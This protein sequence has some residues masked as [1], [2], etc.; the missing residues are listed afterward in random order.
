MTDL[1]TFEE[2][3]PNDVDAVGGKGL[4][5]ARLAAGG[6]PVPPGFC[7]TTAAYRRLGGHDPAGDPALREA[8]A[9][10]YRRLGG[11]P[12]AVRSSATVE[13]R[14][15]ASFAGQQ[16]TILGVEG[17]DAVCAAVG[18]CWVSLHTERATAYRRRQGMGDDEVAMAVVVQR[19]VAAEVAGVLFTC[20]PLDPDGRRM[21]VE[22]SWGLGESV[23]AGKVTPDRYQIDRDSGAVRERYIGDK[24]VE[25]TAGGEREVE[26]G[27]RGRPCL[28]DKQ[29]AELSALGR[30]VEALYGEPRDVEWAW[31]EGRIWLLQARPITA[32]PEAERQRARREE[33]AAATALAEP[34]GTVW[35][36]IN[37]SESLPAPT[38]MTW[39]LVR[40]LLSGR[41]GQGLMYED[42]GI[43]L[44]KAVR[45]LG[46]FDLIAG[47]TYCN[48]SR[49]ARMAPGFVPAVYRFAALKAAPEQA[50]DPRPVRDPTRLGPLDWLSLPLRLPGIV[51]RSLTQAGRLAHYTRTFADHFRN[52][53]APRFRDEAL[54]AAHDDLT[55]L[56]DEALLARL[57]YWVRRTLDEFARD[58]LKPTALAARARVNVQRWLTRKLGPDRARAAVNELAAG[59]R[60]ESDMAGA[61]R[62]VLAGRIDRAAFLERFG[63][64]GPNEMELASPRWAE[65]PGALGVVS[66]AG[67]APAA[68]DAPAPEDPWERVAAEARLSGLE[69]TALEPQVRVMRT[70][71]ALR[72]EARHHLTY[73]YAQLR[74]VLLQIDRRHRLHGGVFYLTPEELPRLA[75]GQDLS[76]LVA[77]RKRRRV[78]CLTL[79]APAVLFSDDLEAIGRPTNV[80]A[81]EAGSLRGVPLAAGLAEGTV[82]VL[83]EPRTGPVPPGPYVLVCPST[84][85]AWMPLFAHAAALVMESGGVLSHG[86]LVAREYGIPAVAGLPGVQHRLRTGQRLRVDGSQGVVTVLA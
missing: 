43:R 34:G 15:S 69:R 25:V 46:T 1:R 23:V 60:P 59:V 13:D 39:A 14:E 31:G 38:P 30:H 76:A 68:E 10:A 22:A 54:R 5:L 12:V 29:L 73:G 37:L 55:C 56:D 58:S 24:N 42:F 48:L 72:E 8:I 19:L 45:E 7:I 62:D 18:R 40:H 64:R 75:A 53:I 44:P 66:A 81:M 17:E 20:D 41:S 83:H 28:D 71:E 49:Q 84:E 79:E 35:A 47:R 74:A 57:A 86:A 16:E 11:G 61:I 63:H 2:I 32:A 33:I 85:P 70:F 77:R 21:L 65:D 52:E 9:T 82:L 26:A 6:L 3:G 80:G 36:R 51:L 67:V 4:S 50:L 27:R 78:A